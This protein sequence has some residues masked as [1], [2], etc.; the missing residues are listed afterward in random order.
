MHTHQN[1]HHSWS[2]PVLAYIDEKFLQLFLFEHFPRFAPTRKLLTIQPD[3]IASPRAWS[4]GSAYPFKCLEEVIDLEENFYFRPYTSSLHSDASDLHQFYSSDLENDH[5]GIISGKEGSYDFWLLCT[6]PSLLPGLIVMDRDYPSGA[7][8]CPITYRPNKVSCQ[9]GWDQDPK[10]VEPAFCPIEDLRKKVLFQSV[11][12]EYDPDLD[13]KC[14]KSQ[15]SSKRKCDD[16][17][18]LAEPTKRGKLPSSNAKVVRR[19]PKKPIKPPVDATPPRV[20]TS[21]RV[22]LSSTSKAKGSST[23]ACSPKSSQSPVKGTSS[24]LGKTVKRRSPRILCKMKTISN[25]PNDPVSFGDEDSQD[26]DSGDCSSSSTIGGVSGEGVAQDVIQDNPQVVAEYENNV[27]S[28]VRMKEILLGVMLSLFRWCFPPQLLV[29]IL[30][31]PSQCSALLILQRNP[32]LLLHSAHD[33]F[34]YFHDDAKALLCRF[35]S[36]NPSFVLL[37]DL[38]PLFKRLG[39]GGDTLDN[40]KLI[41]FSDSLLEK[42]SSKLKPPSSRVLDFSREEISSKEYDSL[43]SDVSALQE[44]I[45]SLTTELNTMKAKLA[46][47]SLE[48]EQLAKTK[49]A[50]SSVV[51]CDNLL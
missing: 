20:S 32:Q 1:L 23:V 18:P 27:D 42:L 48:R 6:S 22:P 26:E 33:E 41:K 4:W 2:F 29:H 30:D 12:P 46:G 50:A 40:L 17:A 19:S 51:T 37:V 9:L 11:L 25:T 15:P 45:N 5:N 38:N 8:I 44:R 39:Y 47:V 36:L 43:S 28:G 13:A 16:S 14:Y 24:L 49:E 10:N 3:K 7:M 21:S 35:A 31:R 34:E